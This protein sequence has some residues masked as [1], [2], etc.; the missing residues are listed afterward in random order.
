MGRERQIRI[1]LAVLGL[2][3]LAVATYLSIVHFEG[4]EP[5][6]VAG[7]EGCSKVQDS[8]YAELVGIPVP[9]IGVGGYLTVL[10]AAALPGDVGR[11]LGLFAGLVGVGFSV[12]LTYLELFE[13][14]AIC[15]WCVASAVIMCLVLA[16]AAIR[17]FRW[18]GRDG[19]PPG[20]LNLQHETN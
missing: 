13:I 17:A 7:G 8:D 14:E 6:C 1:L 16:A 18:G 3:G 4:G 15:Q 11:F 19:P 2:A 10:L 20:D 12:Y 5:V 9:V